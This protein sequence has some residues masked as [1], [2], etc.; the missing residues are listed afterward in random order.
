MCGGVVCYQWTH[1]ATFMCALKLTYKPSQLL[2]TRCYFPSVCVCL[3]GVSTVPWDTHSEFRVSF[4][5]VPHIKREYQGITGTR[6][7]QNCY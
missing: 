4:A 3:Y 2:I 7:E 1:C 6:G 5:C